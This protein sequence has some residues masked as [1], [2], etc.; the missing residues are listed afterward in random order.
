MMPIQVTHYAGGMNILSPVY[1]DANFLI[2]FMH[3]SHSKYFS[4]RELFFELYAQ[5]VEI[6]IS[7]LTID[8]FWWGILREWHRAK[9]GTD[10]RARDIKT[11]PSI[12]HAY[13]NNLR[14]NT[15]NMLRWM[16]TTFLPTD[17]VATRNVIEYALDL[18]IHERIMPRDSFHVALAVLSKSKGFIT[19]DSDFDNLSLSEGNLIVYKF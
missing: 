6:F 15:S 9:T 2:S 7:T 14:Q 10:I 1:L 17:L 5:K 16:N 3:T 4:A 11:N 12:L 8:E 19:S 13:A 18:Q